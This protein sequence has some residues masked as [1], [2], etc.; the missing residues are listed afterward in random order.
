MATH[1][2][3]GACQ[4]VERATLDQRRRRLRRAARCHGKEAV[5]VASSTRHPDT[6]ETDLPGL[7]YRAPSKPSRSNQARRRARATR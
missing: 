7:V 5:I 3:S 6:G 2:E 4:P 1:A